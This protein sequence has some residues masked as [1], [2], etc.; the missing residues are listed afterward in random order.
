MRVGYRTDVG[1][2]RPINEDALW[3][4]GRLFVLADG[5]GGHQAGEVA[6][7]LAVESVVAD[8]LDALTA[9]DGVQHLPETERVRASVLAANET[10]YAKAQ[11]DPTLKGMGTTLTVG[12]LLNGEAVIAH[13]GDSRAYLVR[14]AELVQLTEDHSVVWELVRSGGLSPQEAHAH[15]YRNLLTRALGMEPKIEV[16]THRLRLQPADGLLFCTDGLTNLLSDSEIHDV[17]SSCDQPQ[18]AVDQLIDLANARGAPDNVSVILAVPE[19]DG[20]G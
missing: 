13:V 2:M 7:R 3:V 5:M 14:P 8:L 4:D 20:R 17:I 9:S 16:D 10:V 15:P 1:R 11:D 12:L 18:A 6:S 19:G